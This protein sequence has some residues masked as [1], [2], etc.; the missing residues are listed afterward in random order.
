[1]T[2]AG[3]ADITSSE[4]EPGVLVFCK[5]TGSGYT[6]GNLYERNVDNTG[7]DTVGLKSHLHTGADSGGTQADANISNI[8]TTYTNDKR[9]ARANAWYQTIVSTG[10]IADVPAGGYISL[11]TGTTSGGSATMGDGGGVRPV[12]SQRI[13]FMTILFS[14][15]STNFQVKLGIAAEDIN[16]GNLTPAKFGMEACSSTGTNWLIFSSDGTT[17]STIATSAPVNV[18]RKYELIC[19]PGTSIEFYVDSVL[20]ATKT[21]NIPSTGPVAAFNDQFRVGIKNT[22][23]ENKELRFYGVLTEGT[24]Q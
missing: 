13:A 10:S 21:T 16:A 19:T 24:I 2:G 4:I 7:F 15:L 18:L 6:E 11:Q 20:T 8:S 14:S 1:M 12:F 22:A 3:I 17:R 5:E 9:W 23:A